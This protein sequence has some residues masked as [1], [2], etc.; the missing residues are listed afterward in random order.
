LAA[1]DAWV[2]AVGGAA[3]LVE[4]PISVAIT[5]AKFAER[6]LVDV[7]AL[8]AAT[9]G[10]VAPRIRAD[11]HE[12]VDMIVDAFTIGTRALGD[13]AR[14]LVAVRASRVESAARDGDGGTGGLGGRPEVVVAL[15]GPVAPGQASERPLVLSNDADRETAD[16]RFTASDLD[17]P[18]GAR[19]PGSL[20]SFDPP[21][22]AV[23][24]RGTG[25]VVARL[26]VP[27]GSPRG[28]YEGVVHG[29]P[30]GQQA[31]LRVE[32]S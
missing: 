15:P 12:A 10:S 19:I 20:V 32:V 22:L 30:G 27:P 9:A 26:R 14:G 1:L 6:T 28:T 11:W 21:S 5:L 23:E 7:D 18:Q 29:L 2:E 8:R 25:R 13:R 31:R 16:M 17:G 24:A 4:Q 3:A